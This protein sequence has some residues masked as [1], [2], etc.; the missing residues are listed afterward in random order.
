[1]K[2]MPCNFGPKYLKAVY[3]KINKRSTYF[4]APSPERNFRD[5]LEIP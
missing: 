2:N 3:G 4:Y 5:A 1:M